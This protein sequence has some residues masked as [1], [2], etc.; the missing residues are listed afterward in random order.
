MKNSFLSIVLIIL[1]L[2]T[3]GQ[4]ISG[5]IVD[6][7]LQ[8]LPFA[9]VVLLNRTDSSYVTGTVT[10]DD[11]TFVLATNYVDGLL[12][13]SSVG[14]MTKFLEVKQGNLGH[15]QLPADT[16]ALGEIV[17]KGH[18]PI[19]RREHEMTIFDPKYMPKIE[20]LNATD[21]LKFAPG[22]V[23]TSAGEIKV[24]GKNAAVFVN[25]RQLSAS[26]LSSYLKSLKASD[27]E[28]IEV[29][30]N[31]GGVRDAS[32]EGGVVNIVTK[33]RMIGFNGSADIYVSTPKSGY[34]TIAPTA[35]LFF[36]T[37]KWNVYGSYSFTQNKS[38]QYSE[39][40]N[41]YL[42]EGIQ[43][44]SEGNYYG[45][46]KKHVYKLGAMFNVSN[47]HILGLEC[48]GISLSPT[49]SLTKSA[50]TYTIDNRPYYGD[51]RQTYMSH[52]D[53]YNVVGS[54][55]WNIDDRKSNL[56]CLLN[57]NN[58]NTTS[59]NE[60]N[61]TYPTLSDYNVNESDI[62]MS[63]GENFSS[64]ID[65]KKNYSNGLNLNAG[66]NLLFSNR[67][68][69]F[70][71]VD[72]IKNDMTRTDWHYRENIYGGYLGAS[73]ELGRW[74]MK[75]NLRIEATDIKGRASGSKTT[76]KN[77]VDWFPYFNLSYSTNRNFN[78]S[79]SYSRSIYRP[80]FSLM[81]GYVNRVSDIL[82]DKGNPDLK[83]E[84]TDA[85]Y[86][87]VSHGNHSVS[88]IYRHKPNTITELFEVVDGI[89]Y[90]T[91][92]NNGSSS[93]TKFCYSYGG[94]ILKW[95]QTNIYMEGSYLSVP[96]SYN[97]THLLSGLVS[98]NNRLSWN[99]IC[100]LQL[101]LFSMSPIIIGNGYQKGYTSFDM[102]IER[103]FLKNAVTVQAGIR[104]LFNGCKVRSNNRV[105]TLNY[106]IYMKNQT[107][108]VWLS[109]TYNFST[110]T[111][112]N[113]NKI[114]NDNSIKNRL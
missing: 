104:D 69:R 62:T 103:S 71:C 49:K 90:H 95:W 113:S 82:Y 98:W 45:F 13:V 28:R 88:I 67:S 78:W 61:T 55:Q 47:R 27:I 83:A 39:T 86:F 93:S 68:S 80:S 74:Y 32:I 81:N 8:P 42:T 33:R 57:Y 34:Y 3:K 1:P 2:T 110:K 41:D 92:V 44:Y 100:T 65:F 36:G 30:Q 105:P 53:F 19:V 54:Y 40:T 7:M 22:V 97:K 72:N 111:K 91:N 58:K 73:K 43:H 31:H 106:D 64:K 85:L 94:N 24:A 23:L 37:E 76:K 29:M 89:T 10:H 12:K 38:K 59:D 101:G 46:D 75:V 35:N 11:G 109:L 18:K 96:Q 17:V 114:Q 5:C 102:S 4:D 26:E 16:F 108:Q 25:D 21:V 48:N 20:A 9:N 99:K 15:I 50:Q 60:L 51:A 63:N 112:A 56:R 6:E 87:T 52:S 70:S 107:R 77:Y 84:L 14:Y 79:L 66:N